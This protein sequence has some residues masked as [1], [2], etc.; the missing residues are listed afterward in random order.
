MARLDRFTDWQARAG[1][2]QQGSEASLPCWL[3][4][5]TGQPVAVPASASEWIANVRDS[6]RHD[7]VSER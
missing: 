2:R 6:L 1:K 7:R 3:V 5:Q 4:R